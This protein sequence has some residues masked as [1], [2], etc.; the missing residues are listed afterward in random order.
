MTET[1]K[2]LKRQLR[3]SAGSATS[4][5]TGARRR[6]TPLRLMTPDDVESIRAEFAARDRLGEL[7][8]V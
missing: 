6:A 4:R 8:K 7:D 3:A 2:V 5:C 1:S